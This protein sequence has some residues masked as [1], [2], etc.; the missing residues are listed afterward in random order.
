MF[1]T[2]ET[3]CLAEWIINDTFFL[4]FVIGRKRKF[5]GKEET[6]AERKNSTF[7]ICF[8]RAKNDILSLLVEVANYF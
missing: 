5:V 6:V 3:V 7:G 1:T 8:Y 4:L 2:G